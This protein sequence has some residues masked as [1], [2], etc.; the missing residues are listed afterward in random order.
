MNVYKVVSEWELDG[1]GFAAVTE[2]VLAKDIDEA[3]SRYMKANFPES[4]QAEGLAIT[5]T[6]DVEFD[7]YDMLSDFEEEI[8]DLLEYKQDLV[9]RIDDLY[10]Y[11]TDLRGIDPQVKLNM[12]E[13]AV[14]LRNKI[15]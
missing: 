4:G 13:H 3:H 14:F 8:K 15:S 1:D 11:V 7:P 9:T 6:S 10:E 12:L 2:N 5:I